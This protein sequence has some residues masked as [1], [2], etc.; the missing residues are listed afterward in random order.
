VKGGTDKGELE[1][2][3]PITAHT[4]TISNEM[5]GGSYNAFTATPW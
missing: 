1:F 4:Y 5:V 3:T 2:K